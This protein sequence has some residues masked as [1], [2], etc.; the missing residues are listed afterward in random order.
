[1]KET[2][3]CIRVNDDS[4]HMQNTEVG[5]KRTSGNNQ[6]TGLDKNCPRQQQEHPIVFPQMKNETTNFSKSKSK[7]R[8]QFCRSEARAYDSTATSDKTDFASVAF[9]VKTFM[10]IKKAVRE[11]KKR[12]QRKLRQ[13]RRMSVK[14]VLAYIFSWLPFQVFSLVTFLN[15]SQHMMSTCKINNCSNPLFQDIGKEISLTSDQATES[16]IAFLWCLVFASLSTISNALLYSFSKENIKRELTKTYNSI[17]KS[18]T[19][20]LTSK[21]NLSKTLQMKTTNFM[22]LNVFKKVKPEKPLAK[23]DTQPN[24]PSW[25]DGNINNR[26]QVPKIVPLKDPDSVNHKY[27]NA[28]REHS[29]ISFLSSDKS[30]V[31]ISLASSKSV[32]NSSLD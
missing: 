4:L 14:M 21:K 17:K 12:K 31:E 24:T 30:T 9:S 8:V 3:G 5:C 25:S 6:V 10:S 27:C 2:F 32:T 22:S 28:S 18:N 19:L 23:F 15:T 26:K 11:R 20:N 1:M 29:M 16:N 13:F 7:E